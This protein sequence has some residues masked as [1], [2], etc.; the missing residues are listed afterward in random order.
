MHV[1]R[2]SDTSAETSHRQQR[3]ASVV[4]LHVQRLVVHVQLNR[5]GCLCDHR[6]VGRSGGRSSVFDGSV[7][8]HTEHVLGHRCCTPGDVTVLS[9][10]TGDYVLCG[11]ALHAAG[12]RATPEPRG[13]RAPG[14]HRPADGDVH[15]GAGHVSRG[16]VL[17]R[18]LLVELAQSGHLDVL[19]V[20]RVHVH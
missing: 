15:G 3:A 5:V 20:L 1:H 4:L 7:V 8:A 11:P 2:T 12:H 9:V 10:R 16:S 18:L 14:V 17:R 13:R 19:R 6:G